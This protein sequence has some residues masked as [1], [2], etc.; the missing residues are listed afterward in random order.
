MTAADLAVYRA[1]L[2]PRHRHLRPWTCAEL[3]QVEA[4]RAQGRAWRWID[5][6]MGRGRGTARKALLRWREKRLLSLVV[7]GP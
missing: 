2:R 6:R 3:R 4:W 5:A 7:G 1:I